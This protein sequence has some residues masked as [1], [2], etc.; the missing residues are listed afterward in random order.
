M[1]YS[2]TLTYASRANN[3]DR[4][5]R[6]E[7][8]TEL[9]SDDL[10][11]L[12]NRVVLP[13][14]LLEPLL[15]QNLRPAMNLVL[16]SRSTLLRCYVG[17]KEFSAPQG[18]ILLPLSVTESLGLSDIKEA[19]EIVVRPGKARA[20]TQLS[21]RSLSQLGDVN[22]ES[23]LSRVIPRQYVVVQ[24]GQVLK[25]NYDGDEE[26]VFIVTDF[27]PEDVEAVMLVDTNVALDIEPFSTS[28]LVST[29]T[30]TVIPL[31]IETSISC[32]STASY[33]SIPLG[34]EKDAIYKVT[35]RSEKILPEFYFSFKTKKPILT[36]NQWIIP[37]RKSGGSSS[38]ILSLD[39]ST[40]P[41][42]TE[43]NQNVNVL[44]LSA[45]NIYTDQDILLSFLIEMEQSHP[46]VGVSMSTSVLSVSDQVDATVKLCPNC[47]SKIPL[48]SYYLH[49][50]SCSRNNFR[51]AY[52]NCGLIFRKGSPEAIQHRHCNECSKIVQQIDQERHSEIWHTVH[53]CEN[54]CGTRTFLNDLHFHTRFECR[55]RKILCRFCNLP[56]RAGPPASSLE[57]REKGL[58]SHEA[59]I[60]GVRTQVCSLCS[61][62]RHISMKK[63]DEHVTSNHPMAIIAKT[64]AQSNK[65]QESVET[66]VDETG[67]FNR[68]THWRCKICT[69]INEIKRVHCSVCGSEDSER[70]GSVSSEPTSPAGSL[71]E[72]PIGQVRPP[73]PRQFEDS[74]ERS[75]A[76][77]LRPCANRPCGARI[78]SNISDSQTIRRSLCGRCYSLV[79]TLPASADVFNQ[80]GSSMEEDEDVDTS[81]IMN[82]LKIRYQLQISRGCENFMCRNIDYCATARKRVSFNSDA[83][84]AQLI[85]EAIDIRFHVCVVDNAKFI[86]PSSFSSSSSSINT[87]TLGL[88]SDLRFGTVAPT[89][90]KA[91]TA[92]KT[93][94]AAFFP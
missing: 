70:L 24:K 40:F 94:G 87:T 73:Q 58:S 3:K 64:S 54:G 80:E 26:A 62:H 31:G 90:K 51:C 53:S 81:Q 7:L 82:V 44:Y 55:N 49:E 12:G 34:E 6:T 79:C 91:A 74:L 50:L 11:D 61:P 88:G 36:D 92:K 13:P 86:L 17:V 93:I 47:K 4:R 85:S 65:E 43:A 39:M 23:F 42:D 63:F 2:A 19:S 84:L 75:I 59:D 22:L 48:A 67:N 21:L 68:D 1:S 38:M 71:L 45:K 89:S 30:S 56:V 32:T 46:R 52:Q 28:D 37:G 41:E 57:D 77:V 69:V 60:C 18:T 83:E 20:A 9:S 27:K 10:F 76:P 16:T 33:F 29:S 72:P 8:L 78:P 25:F 15:Q 66:V 35:I 5:L 14:E